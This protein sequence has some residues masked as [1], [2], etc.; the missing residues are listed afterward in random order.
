MT[1][2]II[3]GLLPDGH[4]PSVLKAEIKEMI[5]REA[6]AADLSPLATKAELA[7]AKPTAEAVAKA[8]GYAVV[9]GDAE[10]EPTTYGVRT[11][12][13]DTSNPS[14]YVPAAPT[15]S[16]KA[17]T[18]TI[19]AA[20]G[21]TYK[22]DGVVVGSGVHR[23]SE[24]FP[25]T[26][27]VVAEPKPGITF[28]VG[29]TTEWAFTFEAQVIQYEDA[30]LPLTSYLRLDDAP[31]TKRPRDRGTSPLT[32]NYDLN[33]SVEFGGAGIGVGGTSLTVK[34]GGQHWAQFA[35][36]SVTTFTWVAALQWKDRAGVTLRLGGSQTGEV[37]A[38]RFATQADNNTLVPAGFDGKNVGATTTA[39]PVQQPSDGDKILI[40]YTW[41]G[42]TLRGYVNG[43]LV[44]SAPWAG[45]KVAFELVKP[46]AW[47]AAA[48]QTWQLA[49]AGFQN[50]EA[51]PEAWFKAAYEALKK[52]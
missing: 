29:A 17:K 14:A 40:G 10:P 35:P 36:A 12:W 22:L 42:S 23:V 41:D 6:P 28:A 16:Q 33:D 24:P 9:V 43:E 18:V 34:K 21:A 19:P 30:I 7:E 27:R 48:G 47:G 51:K 8:L 11:L 4:A 15:V 2:N 3:R 20:T 25:K 26:V 1:N 31:G 52:G 37:P 46:V 13:V 39:K 50:G 38:F 45:S 49:G 44:C 32:A 5:K